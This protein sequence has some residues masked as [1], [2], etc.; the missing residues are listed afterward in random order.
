MTGAGQ[1]VG[2][3]PR[4]PGI[5]ARGSF[6]NSSL[7]LNTGMAKELSGARRDRTCP[8]LSQLHEYLSSAIPNFGSTGTEQSFHT[9]TATL[10]V[11]SGHKDFG[12]KHD[13]RLVIILASLN[14]E[15]SSPQNSKRK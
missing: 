13:A 3:A 10:K 2:N 15:G 7:A 14:G 12:V 1:A 4:V 5:P 6:S 9:S 8:A 11:L